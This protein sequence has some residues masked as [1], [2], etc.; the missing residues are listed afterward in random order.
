MPVTAMTRSWAQ[1]LKVLWGNPRWRLF[2]GAQACLRVK[3]Q[4]CHPPEHE[5]GERCRNHIDPHWQCTGESK[6]KELEIHL[7]SEATS[8]NRKPSPPLPPPPP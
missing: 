6:C 3:V 1:P 5:M 4:Q 2:T 7:T 8:A